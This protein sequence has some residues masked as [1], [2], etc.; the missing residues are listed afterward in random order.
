VITVGVALHQRRRCAIET[1][2]RFV[3]RPLPF[4]QIHR[5]ARGLLLRKSRWSA[6]PWPALKRSDCALIS[7]QRDGL[8]CNSTSTERHFR[9]AADQ[10]TPGGGGNRASSPQQGF[11]RIDMQPQSGRDADQSLRRPLRDQG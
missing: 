5:K 4:T 10:K 2:F 9:P 11:G 6:P 1:S 8:F 7:P 3:F